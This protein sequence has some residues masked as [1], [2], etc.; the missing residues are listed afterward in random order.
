VLL[1]PYCQKSRD[2]EPKRSAQLSAV[3]YRIELGQ[4]AF[5]AQLAPKKGKN[6]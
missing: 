6:S 5:D 3:R 4:K 2:P 1:A